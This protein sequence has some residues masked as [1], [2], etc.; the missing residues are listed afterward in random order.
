MNLYSQTTLTHNIG[1]AVI[2]NSMYS[3]SWGGICWAR[4][5]VLSDFGIKSN[6]NFIINTGEVGLFYSVNW[7]TNLQFNIYAIDSNFPSSF[8]ESNLIGSS[9]IVKLPMSSNNTQIIT[10]NFENPIIVPAGTQEIL[11]EVFQLHSTNSEA[12]AFVA[13][14]AEDND[15]SWFRSKKGGCPPYNEYKTTLSLNRPDAKFYITVN[16]EAIDDTPFTI[17]VNKD[18]NGLQKQFSLVNSLD[19]KSV[20]WNFG[21]INSNTE[22]TSTLINPTH[23]FSSAD[24]Y[25]VTATFTDMLGQIYNRTKIINVKSSPI[26]NKVTT[27]SAC[28]NTY[29]SGTASFNTSDIQ[30]E[31]LG[32]QTGMTV[33]YFDANGNP[34]QSPLPNPLQSKTAII[35]ARVAQADNLN[36]YSETTFNLI[37]NPLKI[38]ITSSLQSFCNPINVDLDDI[39]ITGQNI[40]WYNSATSGILLPNTTALQNDVTYYASQ[41]IKGC[42]SE[43]VPVTTKIHNTL[44]PTAD[45]NQPFCSAQNATV[46][47]IQVTG[48][49]TKW[50]DALTNGLLLQ[51]TTNLED[52]KTYYASQTIN[53]CESPRLGVTVSIVNTPSPP[54]GNAN[55]QFCKSENATLNDI[56]IIG[57][58]TKW[59]DTDF[60]AA[61][62]PNTTLLEDNRT[63]YASQTIGCEGDRTP[64]LIRVYDTPMPGGS[65]NKQFCIDEI[66]TLENINLTGTAI[67]WYDSPTNGN[68]LSE[69]TLLQNGIYYGT[70]TLNN[71]ES[72]RLAVTVKIQDTQ[73]P[74]ADSPQTFCIQKNASIKSINITGQNIKWYQSTSSNITLSEAVTLENGITYYAL[75]TINNCESNRIPVTITILEATQGDCINFVDEL[76]FPK[77]FTP[78]N[79][80]YNDTWTIDFAYLKPNTGIKIFNRYG[81]FIKELSTNTSWDG[82]YL[83][84]QEPASDYWFTA[85]RLNGKEYRGHFSLKR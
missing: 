7:D 9:Q 50:Y 51:E 17:T 49:S 10:V 67:K 54:T 26:A 81:K 43:R 31:L 46:A 85:T 65:A 80:G 79:D 8:S 76:P 82:N 40:K 21:D 64:F 62:L 22:N 74:I 69:T 52:G 11:V 25:E 32:N 73:N 42:E 39:S 72:K 83:G 13:G 55:Q 34:F 57:Q 66:A 37:V 58:N 27:L 30:S 61:S 1:N 84:S 12:H 47:N 3:C 36:C 38:P 71:C 15:F 70:Q 35:N 60:S 75:Q 14:T 77:F 41:T 4:K 28:E 29:P 63:Y 44:P 19:I 53:N 24:Q 5:F 18:C 45:T 16:G 20:V 2:Q 6:Q 33:S 48:N 56:Q 68:I 78:N 59:Y 23:T